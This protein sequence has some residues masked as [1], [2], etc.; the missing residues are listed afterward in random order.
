MNLVDA[1]TLGITKACDAS[2]YVSPAASRALW[3]LGYRAIYRYVRL[4][5][6]KVLDRPDG[7]GGSDSLSRQE[8]DELLTAGWGVGLVQFGLPTSG[9]VPPSWDEGTIR[10]RN[11]AA[12]AAGLGLPHGMPLFCDLEFSR[13]PVPAGRGDACIAHANAWHEAV[14]REGFESG[15]YLGGNLGISA[16]DLYHRLYTRRYW[17][18]AVVGQPEPIIRGCQIRQ[19]PPLV[20]QIGGGRTFEIDPDEL[21]CDG[22]WDWPLLVAA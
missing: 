10:G 9:R 20:I 6:G 4:W 17:R 22:H 2:N 1:G 15:I 13:Y 8:L 21:R 14:V 5:D 12:C 18:S 7:Q 19:R 11:A 16:R 3:T